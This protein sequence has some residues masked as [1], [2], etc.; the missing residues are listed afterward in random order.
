MTKAPS[1]L[2]GF[3]NN[4]RH[5]GRVFHIQTEDSGI[6]YPHVI[7]HLFAD[8]GRI[9][10]SLKTSYEE[11]VGSPDMAEK[12]RTLMKEQ[13]KAMF[14]ALRAGEFDSIIEAD[15]R[16]AAPAPVSAPKPPEGPVKGAL[17][18]P[19]TSRHGARR[20]SVPP[21]RSHA[22]RKSSAPPRSPGDPAPVREQSSPSTTAASESR[23]PVKVDIDVLERAA[24]EA[25]NRSPIFSAGDDMPPPP[26]AVLSG[27]RPSGSYRSVAPPKDPTPRKP[28]PGP[29]RY[30]ASRPASIFAT[31]RPSETG[32]VFGDDMISNKSL[33]EVILSFLSEEFGTNPGKDGGDK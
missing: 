17:T 2:L 9:L 22:A 3:N 33:D 11:H 25:S 14:I 27:T 28:T 15:D 23:R 5:K 4:V 24:L 20:S 8:G 16:Q 7:T 30:S 1:P 21:P 31:S 29:G 18:P 13:H 6:R 12:V 32:S 10:K 19:G 26:A